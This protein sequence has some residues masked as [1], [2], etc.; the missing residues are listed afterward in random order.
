MHNHYA[1]PS[2]KSL[3]NPTSSTLGI[4]FKGEKMET[5]KNGIQTTYFGF[6]YKIEMQYFLF[7]GYYF[8]NIIIKQQLKYKDFLNVRFHTTV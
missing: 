6:L 3:R 7:Q 8:K 4:H 1:F 2:F 5:Q